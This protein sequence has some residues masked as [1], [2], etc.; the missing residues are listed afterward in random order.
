MAAPTTR[1]A[2]ACLALILSLLLALAPAMAQEPEAPDYPA[3]AGDAQSAEALLEQEATP[4]EELE[5]LRA[6]LAAWRDRLLAAQETNGARIQTLQ[7]QIDALG[8]APEEGETEE[9]PIATRRAELNEQLSV[10]M[11]P[12][13]QAEEAYTRANGLIAEIDAEIRERQTSALLELGPLP[14]N[15]AHWPRA[16]ED[17][18]LSVTASGAELL[19][20]VADPEARDGA[21]RSLPSLVVLLAVGL[22]LIAHG[23]LWARQG[24]MRMQGR[25]RRGTGVF[26]FLISLGQILLPLAGIY[27][28]AQA[29]L[30]SGLTGPRWDLIL[31]Q[32]PVWAA[33]LLG[34]RWLADLAFHDDDHIAAL[35][36]EA[37]ARRRARRI[38][39]ILSVTF[40][41]R[42]MLDTLIEMDGF[43]APTQ[44]V[45]QFP[46]LLVSGYFLFRLG[47]TRNGAEMAGSRAAREATDAGL[48]RLRLARLLGRAAIVIGIAGPLLAAV[49]FL[50]VGEA[51]VY[52]AIA[53]LGLLGMVMVLQRFVNAVYE[54]ATG[55]DP[56]EENSLLTVLVGFVLAFASLPLLALIWGARVADLTEVWARFKEGFTFGE[57]RISPSDFVL[58]LMVFV[59]GYMLTRLFQ[60]ALRT[61]VLPRTRLDQGGQNA[62][63]SGVGYLGILTAAIVAITAGGLDL[64][65]LAIVAGALSVGIGFGLQNIV[66]NFVSGIIL[67]IERPIGEGDWIEVNGTHGIVKDISVRSTR[68]ET[69]DRYDLIIPNADFVSGTVANY[70]RGNSL[71]RLILRV[72]AAYGSDTRKVEKILL[73]IARQHDMVLMNPAPFVLFNGFGADALEFEVRVILRDID[74]GLAVRTEMNHQIAERFAEEGIE[75]PFAQRDLWLRNPEAL[76]GARGAAPSPAVSTTGPSQPET[77]VAP[78]RQDGPA[79]GSYGAGADV[80]GG[81]GR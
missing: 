56:D 29:A 4:V 54:L 15:P 11:A 35:P 39:N 14:L 37:E 31:S 46:I 48:F 58:V 77:T 76:T 79:P 67:L 68:L 74:Q 40:V 28:L 73:D 41:L 51:L 62:V 57:T 21:L 64:S 30:L 49:G 66:S 50:R 70:T 44:A 9:D 16:L 65:S 20:A 38:A 8:P 60:G 61:A 47:R 59:I 22:M 45:L 23:H 7:S 71:G 10:L 13:R 78:Q 43:S 6:R 2:G 36:L 18:T 42:A 72:G 3:F 19:Q 17:L 26:R 1:L 12:G 53:T 25:T 34:I 24:V 80:D 5:A 69:F 81:D 27:A 75:I 52:P 33:T 32:L 55:T 63:V